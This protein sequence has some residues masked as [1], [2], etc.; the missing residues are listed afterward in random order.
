M[1]VFADPSTP[2]M[3]SNDLD[4]PGEV[5]GMMAKILAELAATPADVLQDDV[6]RRFEF[7]VCRTCQRLILSNP[8]GR[9]RVTGNDGGGN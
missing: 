4:G 3:N 9:P 1:D 8:L 5:P 6:H 2:P 7:A